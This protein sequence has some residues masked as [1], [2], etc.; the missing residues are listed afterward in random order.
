MGR[1]SSFDGSGR[2]DARLSDLLD[3]MEPDV[4]L[5]EG[6]VSVLRTLSETTG[7]VEPVA[8]EAIAHLAGEVV[9]RITA[10]RREA[11]DVFRGP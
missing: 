2:D 3:H 4:R 10:R 8:L 7:A 1:R 11:S 9:K 6:T 5:L